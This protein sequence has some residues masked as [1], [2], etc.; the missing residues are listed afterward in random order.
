MVDKKTKINE[1]TYIVAVLTGSIL[2]TIILVFL[3]GKPLLSSIQESSKELEDKQIKVEKL[4]EKLENLKNLEY[5]KDELEEQNK[6]VLA[7]LPNDKDVSRLFVQFESI[8]KT[9]GA[10]ISSVVENNRGTQENTQSGIIRPVAYT[11]SGT[12]KDYPSLIKALNKME[13]ALRILS[14][15]SID[16]SGEI[17]NLSLTLTVNTYVRGQQ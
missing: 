10:S 2:I 3:I 11:V 7:A 17:N 16:I 15:K 9:S 4:T 14:V 6:T 12:V 8:F 13:N 5:K 1:Y